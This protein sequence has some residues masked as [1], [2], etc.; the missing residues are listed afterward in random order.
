MIPETIINPDDFFNSLENGNEND[1]GEKIIVEIPV[2]M[3]DA[4][5]EIRTSIEESVRTFA[6]VKVK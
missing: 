6:G 5:N 1:K 3:L 4:K 2:E